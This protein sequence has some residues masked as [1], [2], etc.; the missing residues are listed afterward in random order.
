LADVCD[1][2]FLGGIA[3]AFPFLLNHTAADGVFRAGCC[4]AALVC[5]LGAGSFDPDND[6]PFRTFLASPLTAATQMQNA[7]DSL[8]NQVMAAGNYADLALAAPA[9]RLGR[10]GDDKLQ[11]H[12][13]QEI[14]EYRA[15]VLAQQFRARPDTDFPSQA[16][17][18]CDRISSVF[19][20]ALPS[21]ENSCLD[22]IWRAG[23][24]HHFGLAYSAFATK[25]RLCEVSNPILP[26]PFVTSTA[27]P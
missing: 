22:R 12:F 15:V 25:D 14:E 1:A 16:A 26:T 27:T 24:A 3:Q 13:T 18:N 7:Y 21:E 8:Q 6:Y 9:E 17:L 10:C 19:L 23:F 2:A 5:Y 11:R 20:T 4:H